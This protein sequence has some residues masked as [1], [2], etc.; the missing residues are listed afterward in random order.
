VPKTYDENTAFDASM[1]IVM[2]T[3]LAE[4][5][6][7]KLTEAWHRVTLEVVSDSF[8]P[9]QDP[10]SWAMCCYALTNMCLLLATELAQAYTGRTEV[11]M[12][13]IRLVLAALAAS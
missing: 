9:A 1:A 5:Q 13:D 3:L 10:R 6:Q 8:G 2:A 4:H 7:D 12:E 11:E